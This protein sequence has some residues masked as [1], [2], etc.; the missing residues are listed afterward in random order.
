V[1][2]ALSRSRAHAWTKSFRQIVPLSLISAKRLKLAQS[3]SIRA[4]KILLPSI[5]YAPLFR[6]F[7][8]M[9]PPGAVLLLSGG[10]I[11]SLAVLAVAGLPRRGDLRKHLL[12]AFALRRY[13]REKYSRLA[14]MIIGRKAA[15]I[16]S[17]YAAAKQKSVAK[18]LFMFCLRC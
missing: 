4:L 2:R 6:I 5:F 10:V 12:S 1:F 15:F 13:G 9:P 18:S 11:I 14:V 3:A 16:S 7:F 8:L 17:R